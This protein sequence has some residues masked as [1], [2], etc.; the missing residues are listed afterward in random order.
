VLSCLEKD[1]AARPRSVVELAVTLAHFGS[2]DAEPAAA[3]VARIVNRTTRPP[4]LPSSRGPMSSQGPGSRTSRAG[5][6]VRSRTPSSVTEAPARSDSRDIGFLVAGASIG[7]CT[8][9]AAM[10]VVRHAQITPAA[11]AASMPAPVAA[12]QPT[13]APT[14]TAPAAAASAPLPTLQPTAAPV[15][16]TPPRPTL[17]SAPATAARSDRGARS[18]RTPAADNAKGPVAAT[19]AGAKRIADG[20]SARKAPASADE[21]FGSVD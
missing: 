13:S 7:L 5:V 16:A 14:L 2:S 9:I 4:P 12:A 3:R 10:F 8:A 21:L 15:T 1:P 11:A 18:E 19:Q 17:R 20:A 6:L